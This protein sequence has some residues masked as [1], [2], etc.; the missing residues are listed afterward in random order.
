M[1]STSID[2]PY[3]INTI[4]P[5]AEYSAVNFTLTY[6]SLSLTRTLTR[7]YE[8]SDLTAG[9]DDG[10]T[11]LEQ[12]GVMLANFESLAYVDFVVF[13]NFVRRQQMNSELTLLPENTGTVSGLSLPSGLMGRICIVKLDHD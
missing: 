11:S 13:A 5:T 1:P 12:T 2:V 6:P 4:T 8:S 3:V 10:A 9:V 7:T